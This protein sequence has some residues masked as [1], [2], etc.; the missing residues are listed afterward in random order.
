MT[1]HVVHES[2][3]ALHPV[4]IPVK[5][6]WGPLFAGMFVALGAGVLLFVVGL[7]FGLSAIDP[8]NPAS[9][10][11]AG[12]G[13]GI[14]TLIVPIIALFIGGLVASRAAGPVDRGTGVLHGVVLWG[15]T[16]ILGV[17]I[18]GWAVRTVAGTAINVTSGAVNLAGQG[19]AAAPAGDLAS[20]LGIDTRDLIAPV[21]EQLRAQGKPP[22][23]TQQVEAAARDIVNTAIREGRLD[24]NLLVTSIA[25]NTNLSRADANDVAMRIETAFQQRRGAIGGAVQTAALD[26]ADTTGMIMGWLAVGLLLALGASVIGST[27]GVSRRQRAAAAGDVTPLATTREAHT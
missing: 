9:A 16:T 1:Q 14:W 25:E 12:I 17:V 2:D 22:I 5:V 21:N 19:V 7:A 3:F 11:S 18:L 26:V 4:P 6:S 8:A 27:I 20:T 24:R 13:T 10:R 23:T 15:L